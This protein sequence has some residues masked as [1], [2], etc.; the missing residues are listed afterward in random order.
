MRYS[1]TTLMACALT[2]HFAVA[3]PQDAPPGARPPRLEPGAE[4]G[5]GPGHLLWE[6]RHDVSS[7]EQAFAATTLRNQV[8]VAGFVRIGAGRDFLLRV[9][10][11][12][13]GALVWQ[14]QVN[15]GGDEFASGVVA[16]HHRVFVSGTAFVPGHGYDWLLRAY[17]TRTRELLW[18]DTFDLEGRADFSRGT[19]L[20]TGAGLVFL[21]GYGTNLQDE[22]DFNTDYVVR[23]HDAATGELVWQDHIPGFSG[24][25]TLAFENGR[26]FA[27]GWTRTDGTEDALTRGYDA[28]TG[29]VLWTRSTPGEY[30]GA[31][32][33]TKIVKAQAGRVFAAQAVRRADFT[34]VPHLKAYDAASGTL[35]WQAVID[36]PGQD[37]INDLVVSGGRAVTVG[38]GGAQCTFGAE[39]NCDTIVRSYHAVTG[40]LGWERRLDLSG[41]DDHGELVAADAGVVYVSS[42]AG[43]LRPITNC[44]E[45]GQW[46][47]SAVDG[48]DG[49]LLWQALDDVGDSGVYNMV[50]DRGRLIVPG[51]SIDFATSDWDFIVR[52]YDARGGTGPIVSPTPRLV[53]GTGQSGTKSYDVSFAT[54]VTAV[55]RGLV[56]AAE[57][58]GSV[59]DDPADD[60]A[61][62]LQTGIGV[63][64]HTVSVPPRTRTWR[65]S[66]FDDETD[67]RHDLDLYV[68]DASGDLV[69]SSAGGTSTESVTVS[70]PEPGN[71][72]VVVH[73]YSTEGPDA[74]YTL[75]SWT[76]GAAATGN[77]AVTGPVPG[78]GGSARVT[79]DWSGLA[80]GGRYLGAIGY[81][82]GAA[83]VGETMV[84]I[85]ATP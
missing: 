66:L 51:R 54:P 45:V 30:A 22:G 18:E 37:W 5:H 84:S 55:A 40:A 52:A 14:D 60:I 70:A 13:T 15:K 36:D 25:Y 44:C 19:A 67:G 39:S 6:D 62:A 57:Q 34:S 3:G 32:T 65:V 71:Y 75:F 23:A 38:Y 68:F 76:V 7:F 63:T 29:A 49:T 33:W 81:R 48:A 80:P 1:W 26:L 47:V 59:L 58:P 12:A 31:T 2:A 20:A 28:R 73:G 41:V 72:R 4:R 8:F 79:I 82:S 16:D 35:L 10:D 46:V 11:S 27:G 50:A 24:A 83:E 53:V 43:P 17:D 77:L 21:G 56:P 74:S 64:S 9:L 61:V 85:R 78:P 69:A 42:A